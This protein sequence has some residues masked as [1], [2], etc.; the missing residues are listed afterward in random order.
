MRVQGL[1]ECLIDNPF[2]NHFYF[3]PLLDVPSAKR[4]IQSSEEDVYEGKYVIAGV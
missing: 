1:K 3:I 4:K 2:T